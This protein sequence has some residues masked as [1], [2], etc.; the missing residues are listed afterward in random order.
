MPVIV[1]E[2]RDFTSPFFLIRTW[3]I[4]SSCATFSLWC[5]FFSLTLFIYTLTTIQFH[6]LLPISWKN[7]TVTV[8]AL[9]ACMS[10]SAVVIYPWFIM[11]NLSPTPRAI[12]AAVTACLTFLGYAFESGM[13]QRQTHDQRGYMGSKP[14][15]LKTVQVWGGCQMIPLIAE[16]IRDMPSEIHGWP[17]WLSV[18]SYTICLISGWFS[19]M[20]VFLYMVAAVICFTK[21]LQLKDP[22]H[23]LPA[24]IVELFIMETVVASELAPDELIRQCCQQ[25]LGET[26]VETTRCK[27]HL[28]HLSREREREGQRERGNRKERKRKSEE[29]AVEK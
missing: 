10:F 15:L 26:T 21:L 6:S 29:A 14:G 5:F 19:L 13:L 18:V 20:G 22:R 2:A 3:I 27:N 24:N 7:F 1:L 11:D 9:G 17:L 8:A 23:S 25:A 28:C 4:F 12:A 16:A